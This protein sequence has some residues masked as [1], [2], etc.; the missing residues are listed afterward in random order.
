MRKKLGRLGV[1][2]VVVF[3][4]RFVPTTT[5]NCLSFMSKKITGIEVNSSSARALRFLNYC[6]QALYVVVV[7]QQKIVHAP[8]P[9]RA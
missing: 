7:V 3:C 6:F 8:N 9:N 4:L 5:P 2:V 1:A